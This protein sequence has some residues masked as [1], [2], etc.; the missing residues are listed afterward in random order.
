ML[1]SILSMPVRLLELSGSVVG[2]RL[3]TEEPRYTVVQQIP[4][5]EIRHYGPRIAAETTVAASEEAARNLGFRSLARYIFGANHA[6][7]KI[8]MTAPVAQEPRSA[9]GEKITMTAP[10]PSWP[11]PTANG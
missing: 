3:G 10:C 6:T 8:A 5:A 11:A 1:G 2:I 7:A 4:G 9:R